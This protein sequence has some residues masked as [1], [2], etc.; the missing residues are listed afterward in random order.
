M[1]RWRAVRLEVPSAVLLLLASGMLGQKMATATE[2]GAPGGARPGPRVV[3]LPVHRRSSEGSVPADPSRG[4]Q[5]RSLQQSVGIRPSHQQIGMAYFVEVDI[6]SPPQ[7]FGVNLDTGSAD[8]AVPAAFC[9]TCPPGL[10]GYDPAVSTTARPLECDDSLCAPLFKSASCEVAGADDISAAQM[11]VSTLLRASV[12]NASVPTGPTRYFPAVRVVMEPMDGIRAGVYVADAGLSFIDGH[13]QYTMRPAGCEFANCS[14][15]LRRV[16]SSYGLATTWEITSPMWRSLS[17]S[18]SRSDHRE[19]AASIDMMYAGPVL[20]EWH[21]SRSTSNDPAHITVSAVV[22]QVD[23]ET[24]GPTGTRCC[25]AHAGECLGATYYVDDSG[26]EGPIWNDVVRLGGVDNL[27]SDAF[28]IAMDKEKGMHAQPPNNHFSNDVTIQGILGLGHSGS[29]PYPPWRRSHETVLERILAENQLPDAFALCFDGQSDPVQPT[30][31]L[32]LGGAD[33]QHFVGEMAQIPLVEAQDRGH[34]YIQ[35]PVEIAVGRDEEYTTI[36]G[37]GYQQGDESPWVLDCN[38][39]CTLQEHIGDRFCDA[40]ILNCSHHDFD[41]GDCDPSRICNN[42]EILDCRNNCAPASLATDGNCD[43]PVVNP[44]FELMD[45][46][47]C[48]DGH[49]HFIETAD[50]CQ[51]AATSAGLGRLDIS[52]STYDANPHGCYYKPAQ[53][54]LYFN[55]GG[56]RADNDLQRVSLCIVDGRNE[57]MFDLNCEKFGFD[58]GDCIPAGNCS[59]AAEILD[60]ANNC[61]PQEWIGDGHC[62]GQANEIVLNCSELAFDGGDCDPN[63]TC[64]EDEMLDS[65]NNCIL[66][67]TCHLGDV[68][69][70]NDRCAPGEW[71]GDGS[72]DFDDGT[73]TADFNCSAFGYDGGACLVNATTGC[74]LDE[75]KNCLS[76]ISSSR[77]V[78]ASWVGDGE[79]QIDEHGYEYGIPYSLN[80]SE[81]SF[82]GGDCTYTDIDACAD[83]PCFTGVVC[84]DDAASTGY[85]CGAC[86]IGYSGDGITCTDTDECAD[87]P[88]SAGAAC[89]DNTAPLTGFT[90]ATS[91]P[92]PPLPLV[93]TCE[94][95]PEGILYAAINQD[96]AA[97]C[98]A[99]PSL[100]DFAGHVC[101]F[102]LQPWLQQAIT[103]RDLCPVTC[104]VTCTPCPLGFEPDPHNVVCIDI[105]E[106]ELPIASVNTTEETVPSMGNCDTMATAAGPACLNTVGAYRCGECPIG[107]ANIGFLDDNGRNN[108]SECHPDPPQIE[109]YTDC[110]YEDDSYCDVPEYC[111]DGTDVN[112]CSSV[113]ACPNGPSIGSVWTAIVDDSSADWSLCPGHSTLA[114]GPG[115]HYTVAEVDGQCFRTSQYS[116]L[117][118]PLPAGT[119]T[120]GSGRSLCTEA[121]CGVGSH[122]MLTADYVGVGDASSGCLYPG[123]VGEIVSISSSTGHP[124]IECPNGD[125]WFYRWEALEPASS[126]G[127]SAS[128]R[129]MVPERV[130]SPCDLAECICDGVDLSG[131]EGNVFQAPT[132]S[133]GYAY[134]ISICSEIP[135]AELPTGCQQY[136]EHPAVVKYKA[137]N[138]ADCIEIGSVGPCSQGACGMAGASTSAGVTVTYTYTYGCKNTFSLTLSDTVVSPVGVVSNE[139]T[140][141]YAA[142]FAGL[143]EE[144]QNSTRL[145][146]NDDSTTSQDGYST[147]SSW[148]DTHPTDCG[149]FDD[150][151]FTAARQCCVCGGGDGGGG[152][153]PAAARTMDAVLPDW[154][155]IIVDS[156]DAATTYLP[157]AVTN[158]LFTEIRKHVAGQG[159]NSAGA[160][161]TR[162]GTTTY[163]ASVRCEDLLFRNGE[164]AAE[165]VFMNPDHDGRFESADNFPTVRLTFMTK[166][167]EPKHVEL[168]PRSYLQLVPALAGDPSLY[169]VA[170]GG[171]FG[172]TFTSGD[173]EA[174]VLCRQILVSDST[175]DDTYDTSLGA[176]FIEEYYTLFDR[177]SS[178]I[179]IATRGPCAPNA[180]DVLTATCAARTSSCDACVGPVDDLHLERGYCVW[181]P[182]QGSCLPHHSGFVEFPCEDALG[183]SVSQTDAAPTTCPVPVAHFRDRGQDIQVH[184]AP[185]GRGGHEH[186]RGRNIAHNNSCSVHDRTF[187]TLD[188]LWQYNGQWHN[189][190]MWKQA[191]T[192]PRVMLF[193]SSA[194]GPDGWYIFPPHV[195]TV[196]DFDLAA[197]ICGHPCRIYNCPTPPASAQWA[198]N[199]DAPVST[200]ATIRPFG[201]ED[202]DHVEPICQSLFAIMIAYVKSNGPAECTHATQQAVSAFMSTCSKLPLYIHSDGQSVHMPTGRAAME[203]LSAAEMPG[204]E[205]CRWGSVSFDENSIEVV[206]VDSACSSKWDDASASSNFDG[207]YAYAGSRTWVRVVGVSAAYGEFLDFPVLRF[208][209]ASDSSGGGHWLL[210]TNSG[211]SECD[212][213]VKRTGLTGADGCY[214]LHDELLAHGHATYRR[215]DGQFMIYFIPAQDS[216][217]SDIWAF[218]DARA[219]GYSNSSGYFF[220]RATGGYLETP[221]DL[222]WLDGRSSAANMQAVSGKPMAVSPYTSSGVPPRAGLW[223]VN[224]PAT[225]RLRISGFRCHATQSSVMVMEPASLNGKPY[226]RKTGDGSVTLSGFRCHSAANAHFTVQGEINGHVHYVT[227]DGQQQ[228][229]LYFVR[230]EQLGGRWFLDHDTNSSQVAAYSAGS[231][232]GGHWHEACNHEWGSPTITAHIDTDMFLYWASCGS[233]GGTWVFGHLFL[234]GD[235]VPCNTAGWMAFTFSSLSTPESAEDHGQSWKEWCQSEWSTAYSLAVDHSG[236]IAIASSTREARTLAPVGVFTMTEDDDDIV[237]TNGH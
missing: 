168:P 154:R 17:W 219:S 142:S 132:D 28:F 195:D 118:A 213:V 75:V 76:E 35:N 100:P 227:G 6:G 203:A 82:D 45:I 232:V 123:D 81:L 1:R 127:N 179:G 3:S 83:S 41:G 189:Q 152:G 102:N 182:S 159:V 73:G 208:K 177:E 122:A 115:S 212:V 42:T 157:T 174:R 91:P 27:G 156:G 87:S 50:Q 60:C 136:A 56:D 22:P 121:T 236:P 105:N 44:Q 176:G 225:S 120:C 23:G 180:P 202:G 126:A 63:R 169:D 12:L 183:F 38:G 59:S 93:T 68:F 107:F 135:T 67:P 95:D 47:T 216:N 196:A 92:P 40:D 144:S 178:S 5:H 184:F 43:D 124:H 199:C 231:D 171:G 158:L 223:S 103:I 24:L 80:C 214:A 230:T 34:Y 116:S 209:P 58:G 133:E 197:A 106:C 84:T 134:M 188:G 70:C 69:D 173:P 155:R 150:D 101:D 13:P 185:N 221:S 111:A 235:R 229:H 130:S 15:L 192:E 79:C 31:I 222:L 62:D 14:F 114:F 147:C 86:L 65:Q 210:E 57:H 4:V 98:A 26:F 55:A 191:G 218:G 9:A 52:V 234:D 228:M 20:G 72:C 167:G 149:H 215:A 160:C 54:V 96:C 18:D 165:C 220:S 113:L 206:G 78:P 21:T 66:R 46:G 161:S 201:S 143:V 141:T 190:P 94:D 29:W 233:S 99:I 90:C 187:E 108:G 25:A 181:C 162:L 61:A 204:L 7:R 175:V 224:C 30:S 129:D 74:L 217:H 194:R 33:P 125:M 39:Q 71:A 53:Q 2:A 37:C 145:C 11:T 146:A 10:S 200:R 198:F 89:T 36:I 166:D 140:Y 211:E 139:C 153:E 138:P 97:A 205:A 237:G 19:D 109:P 16:R 51:H 226:W 148:Y 119:Y 137:N 193:M 104:N 163:D 164:H 49:H 131:F 32:D 64:A 112:D 110:P 88:C 77:C 85:T 172:N 117:W 128:A 48:S 8:L 186:S 151:D 170:T 207:E